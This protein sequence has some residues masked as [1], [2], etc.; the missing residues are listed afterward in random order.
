MSELLAPGWW[1]RPE[2]VISI[3]AVAL[4]TALVQP[5]LLRQ[6]TLAYTIVAYLVAVLGALGVGS[7][8]RTAAR[9]RQAPSPQQAARIAEMEAVLG[10]PHRAQEPP[11]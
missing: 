11:Q 2:V 6:G 1:R 10:S 3:L 7:S 9:E 5:G 4:Q 8:L